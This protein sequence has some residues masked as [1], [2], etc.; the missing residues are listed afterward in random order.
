MTYKNMAPTEADAKWFV[1]FQVASHTPV[2]KFG[3]S[4]EIQARLFAEKCKRD[5]DL[6]VELSGV[7]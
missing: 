6:R 7:A 3:F 2:R 1:T 5:L 4:D